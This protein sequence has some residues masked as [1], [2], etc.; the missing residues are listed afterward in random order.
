MAGRA[1]LSAKHYSE[2]RSRN[3]YLVRR[4]VAVGLRKTKQGQKSS[5]SVPCSTCSCL[6]ASKGIFDSMVHQGRELSK[7]KKQRMKRGDLYYNVKDQNQFLMKNIFDAVGNYVYHRNCVIAVYKVGSSRLARL[8]KIVVKQN[9][10]SMVTV[11]KEHVP[12]VS[13]VIL[14][15]DCS[16]S[17]ANWLDEQ[18]ESS[19]ILCRNHP[20]RHGNACKKI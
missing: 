7:R 11:L 13:D 9:S 2:G 8:R 12:R 6:L 5:G 10:E 17:P 19:D 15:M 14:P 18:P 16:L 3:A 20:E 4:D 1:K